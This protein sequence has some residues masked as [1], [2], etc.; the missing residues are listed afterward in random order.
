MYDVLEA[1]S[2]T[3]YYAQ[4]CTYYVVYLAAP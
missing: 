2:T 3:T 1:T 4:G